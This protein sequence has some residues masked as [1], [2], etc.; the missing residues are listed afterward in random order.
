MT[1]RCEDKFPD[2]FNVGDLVTINFSNRAAE[3]TPAFICELT[4]CMMVVRIAGRKRITITSQDI[5]TGKVKLYYGETLIGIQYCVEY[6]ARKRRE[7]WDALFATHGTDADA[8][9]KIAELKH[10]KLYSVRRKC[11][12]FNNRKGEIECRT[13]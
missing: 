12:A 8:L 1:M 10:M 3:D 2:I 9:M 5:M 13:K 11:C 7:E 4:D 6:F